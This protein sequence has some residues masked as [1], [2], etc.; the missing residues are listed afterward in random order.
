M[1]KT[2][3]IL[4]S[5]LCITISLFAFNQIQSNMNGRNS[6][7]ARLVKKGKNM[8]EL[9]F[10]SNSN[11]NPNGA[12]EH[13]VVIDL[14]NERTRLKKSLLGIKIEKWYTNIK[15]NDGISKILLIHPLQVADLATLSHKLK[16]QGGVLEQKDYELIEAGMRMI[17]KEAATAPDG[18]ID[19]C[20][21]LLKM[22]VGEK[23]EGVM[24]NLLK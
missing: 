15:A 21:K 2:L 20:L 5:A 12:K 8:L 10:T 19:E 17:D 24:Q 3:L 23:W 22:S 1:K 13:T 9:T 16:E 11:S 7:I 18:L 14:D 6:L 4:V